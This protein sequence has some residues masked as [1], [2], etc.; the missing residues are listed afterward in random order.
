[1][2]K[3]TVRNGI[4]RTELLTPLLRGW[5][6]GLITNGRSVSGY[7]T[8]GETYTIAFKYQ[9]KLSTVELT[10]GKPKATVPAHSVKQMTLDYLLVACSYGSVIHAVEMK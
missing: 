10:I 2:K 6:V 5:K 8:A 9:N 1:M 7:L 4:D 3:Q